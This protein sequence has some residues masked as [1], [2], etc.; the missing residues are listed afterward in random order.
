M[1]RETART[2]ANNVVCRTPGHQVE[3]NVAKA[4]GEVEKTKEAKDAPASATADSTATVAPDTTSKIP[5][6]APESA[7]VEPVKEAEKTVSEP[8][9]EP[10]AEPEPEVAEVAKRDSIQEAV[11]KVQASK[12]GHIGSL[13]GGDSEGAGKSTS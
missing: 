9:P 1:S 3:E 7:E 4:E 8:A 2:Q 13:D 11:E 10:I 6:A 5:T 12:E